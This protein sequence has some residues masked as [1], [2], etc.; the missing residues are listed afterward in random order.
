MLL[1]L[2]AL[3]FAAFLAAPAL[4][5]TLSSQDSFGRPTT[6]WAQAVNLA[7]FNP[8]LGTLSAVTVTLHGE[9]S[10]RYWAENTGY[11]PS[12]L[13]PLGR[14]SFAF[15]KADGGEQIL[16][17]SG[18]GDSFAASAYDGRTDYGGTSGH[19]FGR[20]AFGDVLTFRYLDGASLADFVG[21]ASLGD[22]F[23]V[24][25]QGGGTVTSDNGNFSSIVTTDAR[26][27]L[28]VIYD[29]TAAQGEPVISAPIPEPASLALAALA[30]AGLR[31]S[32]RCRS[33]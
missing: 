16:H 22:M 14:A 20:L 4:A 2:S 12:L 1:Q 9:V 18:T 15:G 32:R 6:N 30:L 5:D 8:L 23:M 21:T 27:T 19:E 7:Q 17:L 11:A 31:I 10:Q 3:V 25:A 13:T 26:Y 33:A 24:R 28:N 29:Y